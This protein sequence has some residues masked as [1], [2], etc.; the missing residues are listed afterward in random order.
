M[1]LFI[2]PINGQ[3]NIS[4]LS[5]PKRK[6]LPKEPVNTGVTNF[7]VAAYIMPPIR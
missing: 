6:R 5:C 1:G 2:L 7:L 4:S 3:R